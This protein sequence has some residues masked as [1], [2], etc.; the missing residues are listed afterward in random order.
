M[1]KS[2]QGSDVKNYDLMSINSCLVNYSAFSSCRIRENKPVFS[3]YRGF[4]SVDA[5]A[6]G[7]LE[8][9]M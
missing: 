1:S 3:S 4:E 9:E 5:V 6:S 7:F 8:I 2:T